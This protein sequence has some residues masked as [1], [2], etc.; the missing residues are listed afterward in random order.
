M[1]SPKTTMFVILVVALMFIPP[2][3]SAQ[4]TTQADREARYTRYWNAVSK[5]KGGSITPHWLKDGS[6][7]WYAEGAPTNTVIWKVDPKL[8]T[9]YNCLTMY[10]CG[11]RSIRCWYLSRFIMV[12][13]LKNSL[14]WT[15]VKQLSNS[16]LKKKNLS[17][18]S[19]LIQSAKHLCY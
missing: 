2:S 4:E 9:S 3:V 6:S 18:N 10:D 7:F 19:I 1:F 14:S 5:V 13:P 8:N 11:R 16:P 15:R 17:F 12:Y